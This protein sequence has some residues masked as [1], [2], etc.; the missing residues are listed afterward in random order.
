MPEPTPA[1]ELVLALRALAERNESWDWQA[2]VGPGNASYANGY[3]NG[4][5]AVGA[6]LR[7]LLNAY[8]AAVATETPM[9]EP[10]SAAKQARPPVCPS[11]GGRCGLFVCPCCFLHC[12]MPWKCDDCQEQEHDE[13]CGAPPKAGK[14]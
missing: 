12:A 13:P 6:D 4:R 9:S 7:A 2:P 8:P 10:T 3:E 11:C 14:S 1:T 5:R